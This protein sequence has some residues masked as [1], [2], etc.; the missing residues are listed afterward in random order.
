EGEIIEKQAPY[1]LLD[2]NGVGYELEAPMSTFYELPECGQSVMLHT[3]LMVRDDAHTLYA[4]KQIRDR[5]LFRNLL[6]VNG[7]GAKMA[8]AILSGMDSNAFTQCIHHGD[9]DSLVRIPGVGKKTA[10]R[11]ILDMR[12]RLDKEVTLQVASN[13]KNGNSANSYVADPIADA[14]SALVSLGYKTNEA[15]RMVSTVDTKNQNSEDIIRQALKTSM[16]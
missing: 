7:V 6:K 5:S 14:V 13:G 12:D 2:V 9:V 8:L 4:F 1:L 11:L 16:S 15:S 10:E 3:H